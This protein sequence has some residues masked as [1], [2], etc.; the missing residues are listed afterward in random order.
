MWS[1][2][3]SLISKNQIK[4]TGKNHPAEFDSCLINI[5]AVLSLVNAKVKPEQISYGF[6]RSEGGGVY[7]IGQSKVPHA[8]EVRLYLHFDKKSEIIYIIGSGFKEGQTK[9]INAAK[10][11]VKK[12]CKSK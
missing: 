2:D 7:R 1:I 8:K 4:K 12:I 10:K 6:F 5:D 11:L 9:D 3:W